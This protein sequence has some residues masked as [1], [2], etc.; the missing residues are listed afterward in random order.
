MNANL[1]SAISSGFRDHAK[2]LWVVGFVLFLQ[3]S[4]DLLWLFSNFI[5]RI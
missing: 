5:Y 1:V 2:Y 3:Y 4:Y